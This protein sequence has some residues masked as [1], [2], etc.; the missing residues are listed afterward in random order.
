VKGTPPYAGKDPTANLVR[1]WKWPYWD[2]EGYYFN[3]RT[4][5]GD[6]SYV[7]TRLYYD[8]YENSLAIYS[9]STYSGNPS[10]STYDDYTYG[11][12]V[13]A[14]TSLVP[15]NL[16]KLAG[17]YKRD[18]HREQDDP[19]YP[20]ERTEQ[21]IFSVGAEDTV[22]FTEKLYSIFGVS[23]DNQ[24]TTKA[25]NYVV[26]RTGT[27]YME[28]LPKSDAESWNLQG[29]V[30]YSITDTGKLGFHISQKTRLPSI[31]DVYSYRFGRT[32]PNPDL[33]EE[34]AANYEVNYQD[35]FFKRVVLKTALFY[36]DI[37]DYIQQ[38]AITPS[39]G[40]NQN[41]G[42][43]EQYGFEIEMSSPILSNLDA[44][45]NYTYLDTNNRSSSDKLTDVPEHKFFVYAK[46]TP[47]DKLSLLADTEIDSKRYSST[48]SGLPGGGPRVAK[49]FTLVNFKA[50]YEI[51]KGLQIEAGIRNIFD[52]NYELNEGYPMAGRTYFSN[53]T[54][55]F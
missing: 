27:P 36:R 40:Q 30:F 41:I 31:K 11:A 26:P 54:Y 34:K 7:K 42:H 22:T 38:I 15:C 21:R 33:K 2:K 20:T 19:S 13:E 51:I 52:K 39:V 50:M 55:R 17:H 35:L 45:F 24:R 5:M 32:I 46:Y 28:Q 12:S 10:I 9:D 53:L 16:L 48:T 6:K 49:G 25:E 4:P 8:T 23:Y 44:G 1:Y 37:K 3:S 29:G 43:V 18:V 47:I 14:G